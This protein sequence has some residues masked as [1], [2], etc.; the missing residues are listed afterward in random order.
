MGEQHA[1]IARG[2]HGKGHGEGAAHWPQVSFEP[3]L[4]DDSLISQ[5]LL[6]QLP[7]RHENPER[8]RQIEGRAVL[9]DVRGRQVYGDSP[10][11]KRKPRVGK[12]CT[13]PLAPFLYR[14]LREA[15]GGEGRKTIGDVD[16]D[17]HRVG[18]DPEDGGGANSGKHGIGSDLGLA[19]YP[20][21]MELPVPGGRKSGPNPA[22]GSDPVPDARCRSWRRPPAHR[23]LFQ[24]RSLT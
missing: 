11:R 8:D 5:P 21:P 17:V 1:A 19:T 12:R 4:A 6:G 15:D 16:L 2:T 3:H 22:A 9:A 14:A 7:A 23:R 24:I 18:V 10:E 13:H 20:G